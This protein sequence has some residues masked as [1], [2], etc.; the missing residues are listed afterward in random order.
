MEEVFNLG[1]PKV[2]VP[3]EP[4]CHR[5]EV[6]PISV[7]GETH[8]PVSHVEG[9]LDSV[10]MVDV[11]IDVED[12]LVVFEQLEDGQHNVIDVAEATGLVL[13]CVVQATGPVY[14]YLAVT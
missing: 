4:T 1:Y 10:A 2:I 7:E 6:V 9:L 14:S 12:S 11:Y 3:L 5:E 13:L 8:H